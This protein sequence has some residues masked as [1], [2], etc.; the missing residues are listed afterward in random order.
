MPSIDTVIAE[1]E[2]EPTDIVYGDT[3][4]EIE[5]VVD[6]PESQQRYGIEAQSNDLLDDLLSTVPTL[7]KELPK[8]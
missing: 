2:L 8:Y 3:L 6:L 7:Q 4:E 1:V 5:Q